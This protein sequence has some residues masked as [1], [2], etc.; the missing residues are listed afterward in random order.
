MAFESGMVP[1]DWR[2]NVLVPLYKGKRERTEYRTYRGIRLLSVAG[3]ICARVH[4]VTE[5]VL[6]QGE[7]V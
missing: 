2:S 1:E 6:G 3:K 4:R 5:V 7:V